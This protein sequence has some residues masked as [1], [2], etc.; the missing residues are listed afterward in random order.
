MPHAYRGKNTAS[1][2]AFQLINV[3][4]FRRRYN[5]IFE[6]PFNSKRKYHLVIARLHEV[7]KGKQRYQLIIK[8][9]ERHI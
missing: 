7:S 9:D 1:N 6:I 8:V 2:R 4:D 5:V 3:H